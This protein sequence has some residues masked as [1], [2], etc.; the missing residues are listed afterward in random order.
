MNHFLL[1]WQET[2]YDSAAYI[3]YGMWYVVYGI[4]HVVYDMWYI[5]YQ[6]FDWFGLTNRENSL[7]EICLLRRFC[8]H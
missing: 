7:D 5:V 6:Y 2:H 4:W 3:L 8:F 1:F